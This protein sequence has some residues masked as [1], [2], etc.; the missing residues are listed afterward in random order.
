LRSLNSASCFRKNRFSASALRELIGGVEG[1]R[2]SA[3]FYLGGGIDWCNA[4][5]D[6]NL[7]PDSG[8]GRSQT[9]FSGV[10]PVRR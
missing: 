8:R 9:A 1:G 4:G 5:C 3:A 6:A 10:A 2:T 7:E